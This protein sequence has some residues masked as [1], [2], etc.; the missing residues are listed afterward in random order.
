LLSLSLRT[1]I[2]PTS[3]MR[4]TFTTDVDLGPLI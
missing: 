2:L 4:P 3:C 1:P